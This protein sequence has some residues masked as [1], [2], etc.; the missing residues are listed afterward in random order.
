[1]TKFL[2]RGK[3]IDNG[4]WEEGFYCCKPNGNYMGQ[5]NEQ[6]YIFKYLPTNIGIEDWD[7]H[8]LEGRLVDPDTV[9]LSVGIKDKNDK[10]IFANDV[11][12][13]YYGDSIK[14]PEYIMKRVVCMLF[15]KM[16]M[17]HIKRVHLLIFQVM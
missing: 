10:Y 6:H 3:C 16:N 15:G 17:V 2:S 12:F 5:N 14:R 11:I 4:Q 1:M 8:R 7:L 13:M 9:S